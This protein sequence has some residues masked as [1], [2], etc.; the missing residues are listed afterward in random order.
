MRLFD[1]QIRPGMTGCPGS[2][3]SFPVDITVIRGRGRAVTAAWPAAASRPSCTG[4]SRVPAAIS[5]SPGAASPPARRIAL[6]GSAARRIATWSLPPSVHSTG[7]TA[8]APAG[9]SAPV[10]ILRQVPGARS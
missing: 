8:S 7:T 4:P 2:A 3:S 5:R 6:P 10:M 1:S 9:I